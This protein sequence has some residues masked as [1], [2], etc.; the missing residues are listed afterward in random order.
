MGMQNYGMASQNSYPGYRQNFSSGSYGG[1]TGYGGGYGMMPPPS[2]YGKTA[3]GQ[4]QP[5]QQAPQPNSAARQ[6]PMYLRQ[7]LQQKM[8]SGGDS[9]YPGSDSNPEFPAT[10]PPPPAALDEGSQASTSSSLPEEHEGS[11]GKHPPTPNTLPSPGAASMSSFHDEF[12]SV[13]SPSWPRTPASPALNSQPYPDHLSIKRPDGLLKLYDMSDDP[14]RRVFLDKLIMFNEERGNPISQCPTIS[15]QPLDLYKL[16]LIVKER[17][18]FIEVTKSK[19]WKDVAGALGIGASSSAAYTLRKQYIKHL[20]PYECKYEA[21]TPGDYPPRYPAAGEFPR[22]G[23]YPPGYEAAGYRGPAPD[24]QPPYQP[25]VVSGPTPSSAA[26]KEFPAHT[27]EAVTPV[28][29]KRRRLTARDVSPL[30]AWRLL[31]ALKSGLLAESTWA[32]DVLAVLLHDDTTVLYFGLGHLPGLLEA[33]MEHFRRCLLHMFRLTEDLD[34]GYNYGQDPPPRRRRKWYRAPSTTNRHSPPPTSPLVIDPG[35]KSPLLM[36]CDNF[37]T[38]S[39]CGKPVR[40]RQDQSLFIFDPDKKWDSYESFTSGTDHWQMGGGDITIHIQTH[41]EPMDSSLKFV[42]VMEE[43]TDEEEEELFCKPLKESSATVSILPVINCIKSLVVEGEESSD[44]NCDD[45]TTKEEPVTYPRLRPPSIKRKQMEDVE[46]ECYNRDEPSLYLISDAQNSLASRCICISN[47]LRNLSFVPGNDA[48]MSKHPGFLLVLGRLLV[49]HHKHS[50]RRASQRHYGSSGEDGADADADSCSSLSGDEEWWWD[51]LHGLRENCLVTLAN[52]A[53][54]LDLAPFP[55][56]ISLPL[57]DGLL[58]WATCPS[59]YAQDPL[60]QC[61]LSPQ[62]LALE[63]LCKLSILDNNMDLL[64]ATPPW[65]RTER[66][67]AFLARSLG[68]HEDQVLREFSVVLLSNLARADSSAARAI[69]LQPCAIP[70]LLLFVEQ[71]EQSA[72]QVANAQGVN[73]LRENP[74]LMGTTLDMVRRAAGTLR[75]LARVPDNRP[76]FLQYQPRLLTLVMSQILDQG[77]AAIVA[78]VLYECSFTPS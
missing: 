42:R 17:G 45:A 33:L 5:P 61:A 58:H 24:Q 46:E 7:H 57:L 12:D 1:M 67:F 20:L 48:E 66:L 26:R 4:P 63:T 69:A 40:T 3:A 60:P 78:D 62:R 51:T 44:V 23:Q 25:S 2:Q 14:D 47:I 50:L 34:I 13:S 70:H 43:S 64:L 41:F 53:C 32:L 35:D 27:V 52:V 73:A 39:R 59:S 21:P 30:E 8:Y 29:T 28:L 10:P 54:Q 77:V 22:A 15:K 18:G 37:T 75:C 11:K 76:L 71:A 65:P 19:H 36:D 68:R 55:E 31:M 38:I 16:Y 49:L 9:P 56:E 6:S 74:E 72:Y